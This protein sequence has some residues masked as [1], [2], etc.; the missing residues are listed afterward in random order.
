MIIERN[1][2]LNRLLSH[3]HNGMI[4]IITVSLPLLK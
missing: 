1:I 2:Y 4:K 3:M